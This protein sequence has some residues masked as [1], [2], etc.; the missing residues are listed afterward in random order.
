MKRSYV[1]AFRAITAAFLAANKELPGSGWVSSRASQDSFFKE[2]F[3]A[4]C[5]EHARI[6]EIETKVARTAQ[7]INEFL[8]RHGM[9]GQLPPF[10]PDAF[11]FAAI[12]KIL[13]EWI[14]AGDK[15]DVRGADGNTYAGVKIK[16]TYARDDGRSN[17]VFLRS[18]RHEHPIVSLRTKS[19]DVVYLTKFDKDMHAFDLVMF[20]KELLHTGRPTDGHEFEGVRF[21]MVDLDVRPDVI[22]LTGLSTVLDNGQRVTLTD[23]VQQCKLQMNHKGAVIKDAFAGAISFALARPDLVIDDSFLFVLERPGL[24]QPVFTAVLRPDCWKDP[25]ELTFA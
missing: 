10:G 16:V 18:P 17:L 3:S 2:I 6:P 13:V 7:P 9:D 19:D 24:S 12:M 15:K 25:G 4:T 11:G 20:A 21:P 8:E 22:W 14:A 1:G 5:G 23:A